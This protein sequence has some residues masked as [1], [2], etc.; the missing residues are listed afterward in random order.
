M[1]NKY[2]VY[3][4]QYGE[5][6]ALC[7]KALNSR[8]DAEQIAS[9]KMKALK[10]VYSGYKQSGN[11]CKDGRAVLKD[12]ASSHKISLRITEVKNGAEY[13]EEGLVPKDLKIGTTEKLGSFTNSI[14]SVTVTITHTPTNTKAIATAKSHHKARAEAMG[15]LVEL[16]RQKEF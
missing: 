15:G 16:L 4:E 1:K 9:S 11:F 12:D 2:M 6:V 14:Q 8:R 5:T 3:I 10:E 7:N 13:L